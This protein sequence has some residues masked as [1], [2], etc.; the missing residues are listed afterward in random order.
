MAIPPELLLLLRIVL[1]ILFCFAFPIWSWELLFLSISSLSVRWLG[2]P[3]LGLFYLESTEL[4]VC[5]SFRSGVLAIIFSSNPTV[6]SCFLPCPYHMHLVNKMV[7]QALQILSISIHSLFFF[8]PHNIFKENIFRFACL[9]SCHIFLLL[10]SSR[11]QFLPH[12]LSPIAYVWLFSLMCVSL[13]TLQFVCDFFSFIL[14]TPSF[15]P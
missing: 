2:C 5:L 8:T 10:A 1:D 15:F 6:P 7:S 4:S 12:S 3:S 14:F 11:F 13:L 9:L